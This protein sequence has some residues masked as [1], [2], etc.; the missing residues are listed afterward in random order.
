[1]VRRACRP[2]VALALTVIVVGAGFAPPAE[3]PRT[4]AEFFQGLREKGYY[5]LAAEYLEAVRK[6]PDAP[7]DLV[8]TAEYELGRLALDEAA[9]T[10][11]LVHRKDLLDQARVKLDAFTKANPNHPKTPEALVELARLLVER[12]HLAMLQAGE[13][14]VKADK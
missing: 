9:R 14:E 13:T 11:D 6:Q 12:G 4:A 8:A 1:M 3:D 5:D 7:P 10:G 2:G